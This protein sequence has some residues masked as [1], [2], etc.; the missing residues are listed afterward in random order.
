MKGSA[1]GNA[2]ECARRERSKMRGVNSGDLPK[3]IA[4]SRKQS[5]P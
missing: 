2:V 1:A 5:Q 4:A 3:L